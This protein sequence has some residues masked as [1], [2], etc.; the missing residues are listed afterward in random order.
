MNS[1]CVYTKNNP[2]ANGYEGSDLIWSK[3]FNEWRI[4]WESVETCEKSI[5]D[6]LTSQGY[7]V[8]FVERL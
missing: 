5:R 8:T 2:R 1:F 7:Q 6:L 3:H 4:M